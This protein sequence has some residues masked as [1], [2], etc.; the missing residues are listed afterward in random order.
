MSR[1]IIACLIAALALTAPVHAQQTLS[2]ELVV[3]E[4]S[5]SRFR[6]VGHDGAFTAPPSVPLAELDG[7]AVIIEVSN[8]RVTQITEQ[9]IAITP[10]TSG[11]ETVRGQLEIR[12]A[13]ARTF[14]VVGDSHD[15]AA[16]PGLDL[17]PYA[18]KWIEASIDANGRAKSITLLADKPP[19]APPTPALAPLSSGAAPRTT[20]AIGDGTVANGST[21]CRGGVTHRCDSGVWISLGTPCQ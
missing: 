17:R 21:V 12:D 20:C 16:P 9:Q 6:L 8:G 10:I 14:G 3:L 11:W 4:G 1:L 5:T 19:P 15:Y 7:K 13:M 18:G 2:G